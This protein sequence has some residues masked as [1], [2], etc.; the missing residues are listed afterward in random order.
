MSVLGHIYPLDQN[1]WR[2]PLQL[3]KVCHNTLIWA[4]YQRL[5]LEY[6]RG[7][8]ESI[9]AVLTL[10]GSTNLCATTETVFLPISE[11][12]D[13]TVPPSNVQLFK[14]FFW[15]FLDAQA[16]QDEMIVRDWLT[17]GLTD[18][19]KPNLPDQAD[20]RD[21]T[22]TMTMTTTTTI[23]TTMTTTT[24]TTTATMT[25]KMTMTRTKQRQ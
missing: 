4:S 13:G 15:K 17:D 22:T 25:M 2:Q 6:L 5:L 3:Y 7:V 11:V 1:E 14:V 19:P 18:K 10:Y 8:M 12:C 24:M 9:Y 16:F 21:L 23:T 20:L